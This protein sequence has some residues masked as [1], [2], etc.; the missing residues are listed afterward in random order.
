[1][2]QLRFRLQPFG[3][4]ASVLRILF[5]TALMSISAGLVPAQEE[6]EFEPI[7]SSMCADCHEASIHGSVFAE[8]LSHSVHDGL[9]CLDCHVDKDTV[10]HH[11]LE[12]TFYP[13]YQGCRTCHEEASEEYQAHGRARLGTSEDTPQ[14]SNCHGD[15]DI[16][17]SSVKRS[18]VHP[19]NLPH[20]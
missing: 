11:E 2:L 20:T 17:P 10:P 14:C 12:E 6:E 5:L 8:D 18:T 7:D 1:M 13:G 16:L 4:A 9:D 15:H 3:D 19:T